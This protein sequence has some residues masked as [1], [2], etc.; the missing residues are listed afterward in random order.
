MVVVYERVT[1]W[2][3]LYARLTFLSQ[4]EKDRLAQTWKNDAEFKEKTKLFFS[5]SRS[6]YTHFAE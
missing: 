3:K 2:P 4:E 6:L 5:P 1:N